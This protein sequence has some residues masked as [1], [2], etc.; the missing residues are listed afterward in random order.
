MSDA[1]WFALLG[2]A[3]SSGPPSN[4]T[5]QVLSILKRGSLMRACN[6]PLLVST[7]ALTV[8]IQPP[9]HID[10]GQVNENP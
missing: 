2:H 8:G 3:E 7:Q 1:H 6:D 4:C 5:Q 9:G 10:A